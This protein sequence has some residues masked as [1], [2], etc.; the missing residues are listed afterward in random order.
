MKAVIIEK[1][2]PGNNTFKDNGSSPAFQ[3]ILYNWQ[4]IL[5][6]YWKSQAGTYYKSV[7]YS[8]LD[9][10]FL[11]PSNIYG[12]PW[13]LCSL[14]HSGVFICYTYRNLPVPGNQGA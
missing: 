7:I 10:S 14:A 5:Y 11:Y 9:P 6:G 3:G 8:V 13:C 12:D 1:Y 4:V 2:S